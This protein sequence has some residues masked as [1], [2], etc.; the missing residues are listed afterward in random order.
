[1]SYYSNY[2]YESNDGGWG[3]IIAIIILLFFVAWGMD[4][5]S[6]SMDR[7]SNHMVTITDIEGTMCTTKILKLCISRV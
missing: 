2:G 6:V 3:K 4:S 5:C 7:Q 1:M